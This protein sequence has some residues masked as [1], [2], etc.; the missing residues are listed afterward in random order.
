[1]NQ[2]TYK[3]RKFANGKNRRGFPFINYSLTIPAPIAEKLPE[4]M[5]FSCELTDE[6]LLFKPVSPDQ[7]TVVLPEWAANGTQKPEKKKPTR[8]RPTRGSKPAASKPRSK[9]KPKADKEPEQPQESQ[10]QEAPAE[11]PDEVT[12]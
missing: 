6:G 2:R 8:K 9:P 10:E 1:M 3:I 5:Q 11:T 4:D 12:A 7:E